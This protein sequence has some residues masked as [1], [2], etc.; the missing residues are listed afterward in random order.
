MRTAKPKAR[1]RPGLV[2]VAL[3]LF[4]HHKQKSSTIFLTELP[5]TVNHSW[6]RIA[7]CQPLYVSLDSDWLDGSKPFMDSKGCRE[8]L[9]PHRNW[10]ATPTPHYCLQTPTPFA[11]D[12]LSVREYMRCYEEGLKRLAN[13]TYHLS[14]VAMLRATRSV[15]PNWW[16]FFL[17]TPGSSGLPAVG[18]RRRRDWKRATVSSAPGSSGAWR[19]AS[20]FRSFRTAN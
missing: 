1:L 11:I 3:T 7:G 13:P 8:M 20:I 10:R 15:H 5:D 18:R 6:V 16:P 19:P 17:S 14:L 12:I 2:L 9:Q 4:A